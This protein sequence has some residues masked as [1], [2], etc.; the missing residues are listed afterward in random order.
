MKRRA[1]LVGLTGLLAAP[2]VLR[3][4]AHM[5]VRK[6]SAAEID[7]ADINGIIA[8]LPDGAVWKADSA[9]EYW[10]KGGLRLHGRN[11]LYINLNYARV[12]C[13]DSR[14]FVTIRDCRYVTVC[15][16]EF[17]SVYRRDEKPAFG[18]HDAGWYSV[19][20]VSGG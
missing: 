13:P 20:I 9:I 4:G 12:V 11:D 19:P 5:P 16:G 6:L 8:E 7:P 15:D 2:A 1:L 14:C 18:Y 3:F 17:S 10:T